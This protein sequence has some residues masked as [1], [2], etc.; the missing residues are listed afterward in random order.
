[1]LYAEILKSSDHVAFVAQDGANTIIGFVIGVV[2]QSGLYAR[3]ARQR[4]AAFA[5][6]SSS[7]VIRRPA[8][9]PRLF[10][11]LSYSKTSQAASAQALL[12]SI[13]VAPA[14]AGDGVGKRLVTHLLT[15]MREEGVT[16]VSLSTDRD[17]NGRANVFYQHLGF[18]VAR[19]YVTPEGRWMNEY[20]IDL[21]DWPLL[22]EAS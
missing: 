7:A 8:I 2:N 5:L 15:A 3:L 6:A 22:P 20:V 13:G 12:M 16:T 9:I 18:Q 21:S 17:S 11:A 1:L 19:T 4:W 10:R 14:G